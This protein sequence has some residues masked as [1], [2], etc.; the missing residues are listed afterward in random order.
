[1]ISS[2]LI[3]RFPPPR[4]SENRDKGQEVGEEVVDQNQDLRALSR[5][6]AGLLI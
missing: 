4:T 2:H 5:G 6:E 1:M 3:N